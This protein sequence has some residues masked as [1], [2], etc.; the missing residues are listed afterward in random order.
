MESTDRDLHFVLTGE[1]DV[2]LT[3]TGGEDISLLRA[4]P[5]DVLGEASFFSGVPHSARAA[6]VADSSTLCLTRAA[7]D[8]LLQAGRPAATWLT[9]NMA[10][11]LGARLQAADRWAAEVTRE[12]EHA[13]IVRSRRRYR[14]SLIRPAAVRGGFFGPT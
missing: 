8:D 3:E 5:G 10:A 4:Q 1:I 9:L 13:R 6:A 14:E 12:E 7:F 11:L 2:S